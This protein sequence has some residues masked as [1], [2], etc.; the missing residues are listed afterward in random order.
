MRRAER[1]HLV[2]HFVQ[3]LETHVLE[4]RHDLGERYGRPGVDDLA[5]ELPLLAAVAIEIDHQLAGGEHLFDVADVIERRGGGEALRVRHGEGALVAAV[6]LDAPLFAVVL[7]QRL[8]QAIAPRPRGLGQ[9]RLDAL[10][11]DVRHFA[12]RGTDDEQPARQ[13]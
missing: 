2:R 6:Q 8:E 7:R 11:V 10:D 12:R 4:A 3:H 1:L 5:V 9:I 13:R